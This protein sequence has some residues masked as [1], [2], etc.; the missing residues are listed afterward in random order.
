MNI[1]GMFWLFFITT[2]LQP[3][4]RRRMLEAMRKR[5]IMQIERTWTHDYPISPAEAK[6][7]GCG[8]RGDA[9]RGAGADDTL[10]AAGPIA[11]RRCGVSP[12]SAAEGADFGMGVIAPRAEVRTGS[13][14]MVGWH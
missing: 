3:V 2:A 5:K 11:G 8:E 7:L 12:H 1:I 13:E 6:A 4:L 9:E 14:G 10:S